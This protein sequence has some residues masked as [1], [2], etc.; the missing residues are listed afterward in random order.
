MSSPHDSASGLSADG[1]A[2]SRVFFIEHA[3]KR[4]L[5]VN[6]SHCDVAL[7]KAVVQECKRVVA[8]QPP[9][10]VRTL[11]DVAG[12]MFDHESVTLLK[13]LTKSNAP[14]VRRAAVIGLTGLQRLI[15]EAVQAFSSRNLPLFPTRRQALDWLIQD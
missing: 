15:H 3:G 7:L 13:S 6:Y 10:S 14:Y 9:N 1:S 4:V 11:N 12:T 8:T 5:F 2:A